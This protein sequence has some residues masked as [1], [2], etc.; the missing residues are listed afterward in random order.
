M[1]VCV[2]ESPLYPNCPPVQHPAAM[3]TEPMFKCSQFRSHKVSNQF[4]TRRKDSIHGQKG[5]RLSLC[6]SCF[7]SNS[8]NKRRKRIESKSEYLVKRFAMPPASLSQF[9]AALEGYASA[10]N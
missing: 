10:Q 8:A 4:E 9:V 2:V 5:D 7:T 1:F 6:L 3:S